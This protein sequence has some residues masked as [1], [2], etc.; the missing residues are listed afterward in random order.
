MDD[1]RVGRGVVIPASELEFHFVRSSGPGGQ[2]VNRR[3]TRVEV[4][5]DFERS[6]ALTA[7]Q[8]RR[9]RAGLRK[10]LDAKGRVRVVSQDERSQGQN[11][12][13]AVANLGSLLERALRPPP[14][15]R[16]ATK[17]TKTATEKRLASKKI[18]SR[19]KRQ[20]AKPDDD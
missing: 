9:V 7:D 12:V 11:R 2:N 3:A 14:P 5:F 4:V 20:R 16:R 1:L 6:S 8:R 17:P 19:T 15:P 10:R 18:R 13:R